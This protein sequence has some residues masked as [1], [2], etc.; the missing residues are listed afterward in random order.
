MRNLADDADVL[1]VISIRTCSSADPRFNGDLVANVSVWNRNVHFPIIREILPAIIDEVGGAVVVRGSNFLYGSSVLVRNESVGMYPPSTSCF[2][3]GQRWRCGT[4]NFSWISDA[5]LYFELDPCVR[6]EY[7]LVTIIT[8]EG[9]S[10]A[11]LNDAE[12]AFVNGTHAEIFC[13]SDCGGEYGLVGEGVVCRRCEATHGEECPGG[14]RF[15][16]PLC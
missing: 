10:S 12:L 15:C 11:T 16:P 5:E 7:R 14:S 3:S 1:V 8:A 6:N 4:N 9:G 2:D 13:S